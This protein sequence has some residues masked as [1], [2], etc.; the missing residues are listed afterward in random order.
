MTWNPKDPVGNEAGK[1]KYEIVK[2]T[3]GK[4]L[5]LGSG[6]WKPYAHFIGMDLMTEWA[7]L[8][9]R[10]DIFGDCTNLSIFASNSF[11]AVFSSHMLEHLENPEKVLREWWR[12][13]K[14][15][16]NLVL[17]LPHADLFPNIGQEG[18]NLDHVS[19]FRPDDIINLMKKVSSGFDL[20]VNETRDQGREYSFLQVFRKNT[21]HGYSLPVD[22]KGSKTCA[23]VRYGGIGDMIQMSSI[24]PALKE[25][26]YHIT[27]YA[28]PAGQEIVKHDPH[29][30]AFYLQDRDQVP[31][32]E[33]GEFWA[34]QAEKYDRFINLTETVEVALIVPHTMTCHHWPKEV[35]HQRFDVNY[36]EFTHAV[37]EVPMPP[38]PAFYPTSLERQWA[39]KKRKKIK[40]PAIMWVLSGS[41]VHKIWPYLDQIMSR[42]LLTWPDATVILTGD[43]ISKMLEAG[44]ENESRVWKTCGEWAVRKSLAFAQVCDLVIGPETGIMNAVGLMDMPKILNL[45]HSSPENLSKHWLNTTAL[46]P[47]DCDC[48]PCHQ[49]NHSF[50]QCPR[51]EKTG[52]A[53]CQAKISPED[54]WE[55][56]KLHVFPVSTCSICRRERDVNQT[57]N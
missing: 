46:C 17:Y 51:D 48:W 5:D 16:G 9:W 38:R 23:I 32:Q 43:P 56:I 24:L 54:M 36:L 27:I 1:I 41:S 45:S 29:I 25:E 44:W 11:D 15:G 35:R 4:V 30:D 34:V 52:T 13:I 47:K 20:V 18:A 39:K 50:E 8:G 53:V 57:G 42:I 12:V 6:P 22:L 2:Y 31:M 3:R 10:P 49:L 55:A 37:A 19:D 33:L 7:D 40:G 28:S 26:G 21:G 14:T